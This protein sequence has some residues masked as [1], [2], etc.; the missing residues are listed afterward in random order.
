MGGVRLN[1]EGK[2]QIDGSDTFTA[3]AAG[4]LRRPSVASPEPSRMLT[5][6]LFKKFIWG[7]SA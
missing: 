2:G 4:K 6:F 5:F 3:E 7:M 1:D